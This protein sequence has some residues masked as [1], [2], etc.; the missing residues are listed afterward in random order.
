[1]K[2]IRLWLLLLVAL[3]PIRGVMAV[4]MPCLPSLAGSPQSKAEGSVPRTGAALEAEAAHD[5]AAHGHG[6]AAHGDPASGGASG[7]DDPGGEPDQCNLC[8]AFCCAAPLPG[9]E[10]VIPQR[11]EVAQSVSTDVP[12]LAPSFLP[13]G[14]ERPPRSS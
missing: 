3:L 9:S 12:A 13:E 7:P 5:H 14:P 11:Q 6:H 2:H 1:M 8:S 4:A 10:P